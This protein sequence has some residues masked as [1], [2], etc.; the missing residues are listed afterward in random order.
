MMKTRRCA[1]KGLWVHNCD[2][3]NIL[4]V[5]T[6]IFVP[7]QGDGD[8]AGGRLKK[9][10]VSKN[11][12]IGND[13]HYKKRYWWLASIGFVH[14]YALTLVVLGNLIFQYVL[15]TYH[16]GTD[17]TLDYTVTKAYWWVLIS[18]NKHLANG[19]WRASNREIGYRNRIAVL[20]VA[21]QSTNKSLPARLS[22]IHHGN[23]S[24]PFY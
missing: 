19:S 13:Y 24:S 6:F 17:N 1:K 14:T 4:V 8:H 9:I 10:C 20:L 7:E 18:D 15:T 3:L 21:G 23:T 11:I 12:S 5:Y 22:C 2:H 16:S